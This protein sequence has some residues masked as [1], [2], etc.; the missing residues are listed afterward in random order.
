[1]VPRCARVRKTLF[2]E[3]SKNKKPASLEAGLYADF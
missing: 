3:Y 2:A 1:M